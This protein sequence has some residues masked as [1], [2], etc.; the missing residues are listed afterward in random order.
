MTDVEIR[1]PNWGTR[2]G[3]PG[4]ESPALGRSTRLL[5]VLGSLAFESSTKLFSGVWLAKVG[6]PAFFEPSLNLIT[7][8]GGPVASYC[9][10]YCI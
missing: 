6:G 8:R 2:F 3:R 9:C 7:A 10:N 1:G 5:V 4:R